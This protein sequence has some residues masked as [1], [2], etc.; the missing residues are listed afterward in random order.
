MFR[1]FN[2]SAALTLVA[3]E[4]TAET[5]TGREFFEDRAGYPC[6][7]TLYTDADKSV[8]LQ[9]SDYKD[10]WSLRFI[11]S[12]RSL[13]YQRFFDNRGL[14]D[15]DAFEDAFGEIRIGADRFDLSDVSLF[16]VRLQDLD[17]NSA[18]IFGIEERHNVVPALNAMEDDGLE[19]LG[20]VSL[21]GTSGAL[22]EFRTCSFAAMGLQEGEIVETDFRAEYRMIFDTAFEN[23]VINMARAEHCFASRFDDE[24][25]A[26]VVDAAANTFYP[27]VMNFGKRSE[28]R[29][30]LERVIPF[31][32]LSG[33][34]DAR[35]DGCLMAGELA[36]ISRGLVDRVI[37]EAKEVE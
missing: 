6:F 21:A 32:K 5:V 7:V 22:A 13:V 10:I 31:A 29:E 36:D 17:D 28:Y 34:A 20:L 23:W 18:G 24:A 30:S 25:V 2:I 11:I 16:E 1:A 4:A 35:T 33:M 3:C 37:E 19:I 12:D 15:E 27:G 26:N 8:T 14:R 9:L